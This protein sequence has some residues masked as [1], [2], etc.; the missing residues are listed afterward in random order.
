[1]GEESG[2]SRSPQSAGRSYSG[3]AVPERKGGNGIENEADLRI[4]SRRVAAVKNSTGQIAAA[5]LLRLC[6]RKS[7]RSQD[8]CQINEV[9]LLRRFESIGVA[10]VLPCAAMLRNACSCQQERKSNV[11]TRRRIFT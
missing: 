10:C 11:A 8:G 6:F 1:M 3:E 7:G 5:R 2:K 4:E 9:L